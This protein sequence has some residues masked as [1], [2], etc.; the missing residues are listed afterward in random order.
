M[1]IRNGILVSLFIATI[2]LAACGGG[3]GGGDSAP[4]PPPPPPPVTITPATPGTLIA[5]P[6]PLPITAFTQ[7]VRALDGGSEIFPGQTNVWDIGPNFTLINDQFGF[8][9]FMTVGATSFPEDQQYGELT[10]YT[11]AFGLTDGIKV[12]DTTDG[13]TTGV[14]P[15]GDVN[16]VRSAML[17]ATS[18][19]RLQQTINLASAPTNTACRGS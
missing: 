6:N 4:P 18:D 15:L 14:S 3:G 11:P 19:S 12:A 2:T 16:S 1:K 7:S 17:N 9:L 5:S 10:F 13:I 8:A